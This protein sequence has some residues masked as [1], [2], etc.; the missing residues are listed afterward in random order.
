MKVYMVYRNADMTEGRGPMVFDRIY[1]KQAAA[2]RF[3][4]DQDG[5]MGRR[6]KWSEGVYTDWQVR[7]TN[8]IEEV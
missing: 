5:L 2:I 4:D 3:I 7:E 8:V 6:F 1:L